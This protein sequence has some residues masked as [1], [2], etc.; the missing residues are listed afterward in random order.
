MRG[1]DIRVSSSVGSTARNEDNVPVFVDIRII[2][3]RIRIIC[4]HD[5]VDY[6]QV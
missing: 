5:N 1:C 2:I 4:R 3:I 6:E